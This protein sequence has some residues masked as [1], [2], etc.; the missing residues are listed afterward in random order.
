MVRGRCRKELYMNG[1]D[2]YLNEDDD[3]DDDDDDQ[4]I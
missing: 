3:D 4:R 2:P 1:K